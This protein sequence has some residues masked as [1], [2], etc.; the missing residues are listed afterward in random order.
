VFCANFWAK[1]GHWQKCRGIWC[2]SCYYSDEQ[3]G[4]QV[5]VPIND[6]GEAVLVNVKDEGR[7]THARNADNLVTRFQC[8]KCH[9]RN[10][11]GRDPVMGDRSDELFERC[12]RRASLDAFWSREDSTVKGLRSNLLSAMQK[13]EMIRGEKVFPALGPLPLKDVDGMGAA[14]VQLLKTLDPGINADTVQYKTAIGVS[15]ALS[16]LWEISVQ[17]KEETVMVKEMTKSYVTTNPVK[18][19]W[20]QRFLTGMHKRMG[21]QT[22]QDEAISIEQMN[23]LMD[24]FEKDWQELIRNQRRTPNQTREVLFPALFSVL[25]FCG[26]LR[27]EEVP[28][29]DLDATKEFTASGLAHPEDSKKHAVIALHGRFKNELGERCHLMPLVPITNSGLMPAKWIGR[30]T[31]WYSELGVTR[32][33]VFRGASGGRARQSQFGF[34]IWSRLTRVAEER[35]ELFPDRRVN[36]MMDYSTRRSFRRGATTRAEILDLSETVTNLN[37]RWRSVE[38][39]KGKRVNHSSMRSYYSGIRL[40]LEALLKFSR[41]M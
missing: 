13:T 1:R 12:I 10:I 31:D 33:P 15:T 25:A 18:S 36:I 8:G 2:G 22:K 20:Y 28:L 40:M 39:A 11:Q 17:S 27:G 23:A 35:P 30:M 32:G 7:F 29:M 37:N 5:H 21:D 9:F 24:L 16:A 19:Q 4:F 14:A 3:D 41:A 38:K 34:S 6:D 26:A